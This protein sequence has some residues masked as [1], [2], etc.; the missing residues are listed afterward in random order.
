MDLVSLQ[1]SDS[2]LSE[3]NIPKCM[4]PAIVP[5]ASVVGHIAPSGAN[6]GVDELSSV[7]IAGILGD[8][9]AAL[10]GQACVSYR[11]IKVT[12]GTGAFLLMN[13]GACTARRN[14]EVHAALGRRTFSRPQST[15]APHYCRI[16]ARGT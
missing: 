8:Q 10:F 7:P 3:F 12:Y 4:L 1:W 13:T 9:Q 6:G 5:S 15:W 11:D 2:L 16:Q 14:D